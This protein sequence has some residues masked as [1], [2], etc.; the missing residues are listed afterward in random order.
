MFT[1]SINIAANTTCVIIFLYEFRLLFT[2]GRGKRCCHRAAYFVKYTPFIA[3][4]E[5]D[6][7]V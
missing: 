3:D 6:L 1:H 5:Y 2:H 7:P 4:F